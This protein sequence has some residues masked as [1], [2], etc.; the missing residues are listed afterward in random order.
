MKGHNT[1]M[2]VRSPGIYC[3]N[4]YFLFYKMESVTPTIFYCRAVHVCESILKII[5]LC[6]KIL[7]LFYPSYTYFI[8]LDSFQGVKRKNTSQFAHEYF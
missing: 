6:F 1:I 3:L 4:L 2:W 7:N 5:L 8:S